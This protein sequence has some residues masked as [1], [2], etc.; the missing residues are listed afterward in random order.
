MVEIAQMVLTC[1]VLGYWE[2]MQGQGL[3]HQGRWQRLCGMALEPGRDQ[4]HE[5]RL[6]FGS[7]LAEGGSPL[8][9]PLGVPDEPGAE[10]EA[11]LALQHLRRHI[12]HM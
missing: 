5:D 9:G 2:R 12:K 11:C 4:G 8:Q 3:L 1:D 7:A 6:A 10:E